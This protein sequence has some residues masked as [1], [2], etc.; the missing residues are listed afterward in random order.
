[1]KRKLWFLTRMSLNKKIKTKWFYIANLLFLI[2]IVGLIN[3]DSIIK[4]FGGDFDETRQILVIDKANIFDTFKNNYM[5]GSK[6]IKDY[7]NV[8]VNI[9]DKSYDEGVEEIKENNNVLLLIEEDK[10]NY[11]KAT[12]VSN[13]K[14]GTI[15]NT[16]ITTSLNNAR[17]EIALEKYGITKE[18]YADIEGVVTIDDIVLSEDS[19]EDGLLISTV[20]QVITLPVFMLIMFLVQMIGAEVNEEKTTK[21]MEIIISNVS[22]K[23]HFLSKVISSNAF[24]LI[25]SLLLL[26]Y[27]F[28]GVIIRFIVSGGDILQGVDGDIMSVIDTVNINTSG[29]VSSITLII[30]VLI[31]MLILTFIAYSLLAGI[32]ASMTTNLEDFQQLQTPITV[33]SLVGYYLSVMAGVFKGSIFIKIMSYIPFVSSLLAPTLY[34]MGEVN[35]IDLMISIAL[36]IGT[37]YLLIKY[38]L[39][40]YKVG[41]L[42]YSGN[43][44][45]KKMAEAI[46]EK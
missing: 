8:E 33:I 14:V 7:D 29:I 23:I 15:T 41:I 17:S 16:L 24:V 18:M 45:W 11:L 38:G 31:V 37:I 3:V 26:A 42:N 25:Q 12:M 22:P 21:S 34:V 30:P 28:I 5:A 32:L 43:G 44:L 19:K 27:G 9:Y 35:A 39:R 46:K 20:M 1:M 10:D 4:L 40:I 6:Y 2:L 13:E 36:L